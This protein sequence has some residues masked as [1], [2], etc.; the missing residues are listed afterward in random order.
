MTTA[1]STTSPGLHGLMAEYPSAQHLLEAA[2][3]AHSAGFRAMDA[4]TPFPVEALSEVICDHHKSKVPLICLTGGITGALA[5]WG[6]EVWTSTVDYP[7][8]IGGKPYYS[9]PAFIPVLFECTVLFAAFSAAIG[10]FILNKLPQPYHPVFNVERFR[11][12]ASRDGFFLCI[13]AEDRKFDPTETRAFLLQTGAT[14]VNDV[15]L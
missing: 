14:E 13:E 2:E 6:L 7:M 4:Y 9:W 12:K 1:T 8:N 15:A 5:G 10:M 3:K 11:E